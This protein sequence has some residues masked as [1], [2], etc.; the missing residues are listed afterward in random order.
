MKK[1]YVVTAE[2]AHGEDDLGAGGGDEYY[3]VLAAFEDLADAEGFLESERDAD[4]EYGWGNFYAKTSDGSEWSDKGWWLSLQELD[5]HPKGKGKRPAK[6]AGQSD[7]LK[8]ANQ[9]RRE[10]GHTHDLK[11]G[12][13]SDPELKEL[14]SHRRRRNAEGHGRGDA[15]LAAGLGSLVGGAVGGIMGPALQVAGSV[16]GGMYGADRYAPPKSR[17]RSRIGGGIG[18]VFGPLGAALGSYI[19]TRKPDGKRKQNPW[20]YELERLDQSDREALYDLMQEVQRARVK[21]ALA[22]SRGDRSAGRSWR[23][24]EEA[25]DLRLLQLEERLH[26]FETGRGPRPN[27]RASSSLKRTLRG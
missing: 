8:R 24:K 18:G 11:P 9:Y 15:A 7:L 26:L 21:A 1:V 10:L 14:L 2:Y 19:G 22:E 5:L 16:A 6:A 12:E 3:L 17:R 23:A 25:A 4:E 13:W 27:P 20:A